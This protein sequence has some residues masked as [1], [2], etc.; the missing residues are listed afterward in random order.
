M[1]SEIEDL[2]VKI[3]DAIEQLDSLINEQVHRRNGE[4]YSEVD[5]DD[6]QEVID[7]LKGKK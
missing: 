1:S 5:I 7:I 2:K 4:Q 3:K 6:L